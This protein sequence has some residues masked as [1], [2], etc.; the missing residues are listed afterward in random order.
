VGFAG[1]ALLLEEVDVDAA[2]PK[3]TICAAAPESN[4]AVPTSA[5]KISSGARRDLEEELDEE[6]LEESDALL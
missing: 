1:A 5:G 2:A 3:T 6:L 4:V